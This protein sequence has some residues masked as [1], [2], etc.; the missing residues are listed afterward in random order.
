MGKRAW[1]G[2]GERAALPFPILK[3]P[4]ANFFFFWRTPV[5][6][7]FSPN[8]EPVPRLMKIIA[9]LSYARSARRGEPWVRNF[10]PEKIVLS[11]PG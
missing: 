6:F 1:S 5:F 4:L 8:A 7:S 3:I 2:E 9:E 10:G 11:P